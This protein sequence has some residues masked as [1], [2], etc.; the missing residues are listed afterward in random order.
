MQVISHINDI[1]RYHS[2]LINWE[3]FKILVRGRRQVR[4]S[5][6]IS[7][8]EVLLELISRTPDNSDHPVD[9][10]RDRRNIRSARVLPVKVKP[11][12]CA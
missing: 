9:H 11:I 10:L 4:Q 2:N 7:L 1:V 3:A 6:V 5:K 12:K 8:M